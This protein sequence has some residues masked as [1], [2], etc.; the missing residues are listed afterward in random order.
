MNEWMNKW[1]SDWMNECSMKCLY[2]DTEGVKQ[3]HAK[4]NLPYYHFVHH[5]SHMAWDRTRGPQM[6]GRLPT[7]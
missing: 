3:K 2:D 6:K 5:K 4:K 1:V 7:A